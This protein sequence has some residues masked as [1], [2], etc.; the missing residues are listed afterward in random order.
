[1]SNI[2]NKRQRKSKD[3]LISDLEEKKQKLEQQAKKKMEAIE[4]KI[5]RLKK[6]KAPD[7]LLEK[8]KNAAAKY[9]FRSVPGWT[10]AQVLAAV[11]RMKQN[12][13]GDHALLTQLQQE[14]EQQWSTLKGAR[15]RKK[16]T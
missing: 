14:G 15:G 10:P 3:A 12:A 6:T 2:A 1:M 7:K 9:I 5:K 8:E 13:A 4:D 11:N 16:A